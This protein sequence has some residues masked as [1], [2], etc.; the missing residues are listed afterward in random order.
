MIM[1]GLQ[2]DGQF[3]IA[4]GLSAESKI[5]KNTKIKWSDFLDRT[6]EE[7]KTSETLP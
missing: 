5:W 2:H 7:R 1:Q 4:I 6:A 3:N